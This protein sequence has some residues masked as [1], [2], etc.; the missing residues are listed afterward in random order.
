M[1]SLYILVISLLLLTCK[2]NSKE[3]NLEP[4][5]DSSLITVSQ[6]KFTN[7]NMSI[8]EIE[9]HTFTESIQVTGYIDVPPQS[10]AKVNTFFEGYVKN[11]PLLI[12]DTV[13]KGQLIATLEHPSYVTI[14]QNFLESSEQITY[15]KAEYDR[16][17]QLLEENITSKKN[18]LNAESNYKSKLASYN[19]LRKTL[20]MMNINPNQVKNGIISSKINLYAPISGS[21]TKVNVSQGTFVS[22]STEIVEIINTE[23]I[24]L[25]LIAFEKDVLNI[26]KG[27]EIL[28]S[29]PESS[30]KV[31]KAEVY[32]VGT[33]I[34]TDTRTI[35]VHGHIE[36]SEKV[37]FITG[38]FIDAQIIS[39]GK[40]K[41]ALPKNALIRN[42][43]DYFA[44]VL[45]SKTED[46][47]TFEKVRVNIGIED[48]DYIE[49]TNFKSLEEKDIL[50]DS[51]FMTQNLNE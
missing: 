27:Q 39:S 37:S 47:Y 51:A 32:L 40:S 6:T 15:L 41:N 26:K 20:Q 44:L 7:K 30:S 2:D 24:H 33:N 46:N 21:I 25:E 43:E 22:T 48:K 29:V 36:D 49:I 10:K 31:Y 45:K 28:F 42:G 4:V 35:T 50:L 18:Y 3:V 16:Q 17:K 5:Q 1:K 8:G 14:Q 34:D 38:M 11:M 13:K 19:G 12:G 23:H 9:P